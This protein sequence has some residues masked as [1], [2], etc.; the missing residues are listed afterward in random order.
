[1]D[2][3][4]GAHCEALEKRLNAAS[5]QVST[6]LTDEIVTGG[7]TQTQAEINA[8]THR[9]SATNEI[10]LTV[11]DLFQAQCLGLVDDRVVIQ[12]LLAQLLT[13]GGVFTGGWQGTLTATSGQFLGSLPLFP[14][15]ADKA[16]TVFRRYEEKEERASFLCLYRQM[17]KTNCLLFATPEETVVDGMDITGQS[18]PYLITKNSID[19]IKSES[20]AAFADVVMLS[21][22][23][24][25]TAAFLSI[26]ERPGAFVDGPIEGFLALREWCFDHSFTDFETTGNFSDVLRENFS[27]IRSTCSELKQFQWREAR[28]PK[29][30]QLLFNS[31]W[32]LFSL[33][34]FYG[35]LK[36]PG[37]ESEFSY[38]A[39]TWESLKYFEGLVKSL[40][41]IQN[42]S[43]G[44]QFRLNYHDL[45]TNLGN[46]LAK[47]SL[48]S[49]MKEN[50]AT[51][52]ASEARSR[53]LVAE[54]D[55]CQTLD[56][57][58]ACLYVDRP[59]E[60]KLQSEWLKWCVGPKSPL[61]QS[62]EGAKG[63]SKNQLLPDPANRAYF[64]SLCGQ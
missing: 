23:D 56:P 5:A 33:K 58:L 29:L 54:L 20:P 31:Y 64:D 44:N 50:Q 21:E 37:H 7:V 57:T 55:L 46:T 8:A 48:R 22:M 52:K 42:T 19:K 6:T 40:S 3:T 17:Q 25:N 15:D 16:L 60:N 43:V 39:E 59:S 32:Q 51:R 4:G 12:K 63:D 53:A 35:F 36:A 14:S 27:G 13:L 41:R 9:A 49:L 28:S 61:C 47:K 62:V 2:Q 30:V 38:I 10:V 11:S 34:L 24:R 26:M 45:V 18:G 1:M